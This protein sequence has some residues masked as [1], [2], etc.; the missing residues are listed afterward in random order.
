MAGILAAAPATD[1]TPP[2]GT[3]QSRPIGLEGLPVN[4]FMH[5]IAS[6]DGLSSHDVLVEDSQ[7]QESDPFGASSADYS[8]AYSS[9]NGNGYAQA[10]P[11]SSNNNNGHYSDSQS[12]FQATQEYSQTQPAT[13]PVASGPQA[14]REL[15][16]R[17]MQCR[18]QSNK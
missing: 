13:Q 11:S 1:A 9:N 4:G 17:S 8:H 7:Q 15:L 3:R 10:G 16:V 6:M 18:L 2:A 12:Q 5:G 14:S